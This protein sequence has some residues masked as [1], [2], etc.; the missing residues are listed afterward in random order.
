MTSRNV[1]IWLI[2][3]VTSSF[4]VLSY[5]HP[6]RQDAKMGLLDPAISDGRVIFFLPTPSQA[7][8]IR[9]PRFPGIL[10]TAY[11]RGRYLLAT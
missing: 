5:M 11:L 6:G 2:Q 4:E 3:T 10:G 8:P 1:F 7:Q 9:L